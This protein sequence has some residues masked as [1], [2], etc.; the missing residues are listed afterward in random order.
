MFETLYNMLEIGMKPNKKKKF[1][2]KFVGGFVNILIFVFKL[3]INKKIKSVW[4]DLYR[5]QDVDGQ[6]KIIQT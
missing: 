4:S 1:K 5:N 6:D 3:K 2:L